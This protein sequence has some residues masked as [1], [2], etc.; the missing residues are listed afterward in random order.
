VASGTVPDSS[1]ANVADAFFGKPYDMDSL[2]Q[3]IRALLS[4]PRQSSRGEP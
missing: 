4:D 1:I 3:R 2:L